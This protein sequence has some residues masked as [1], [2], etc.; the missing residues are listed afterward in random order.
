MRSTKGR[1]EAVGNNSTL[2]TCF[3]FF[4]SRA[5]GS[6]VF[7]RRALPARLPPTLTSRRRRCRRRCRRRRRCCGRRRCRCRCCRCRCRRRRCRRRRTPLARGPLP[8][9]CVFRFTPSPFGGFVRSVCSGE[10][11]LRFPARSVIAA[12]LFWAVCGHAS[13]S[14]TAPCSRK[15]RGASWGSGGGPSCGECSS[16]VAEAPVVAPRTRPTLCTRP[17]PVAPWTAVVL[18]QGG[19]CRLCP[20]RLRRGLLRTAPTRLTRRCRGGT[21]AAAAAVVAVAA[22]TSAPTAAAPRWSHRCPTRRLW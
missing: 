17:R 12:A 9:W 15:Y 2:V 20:W 7:H 16:R 8:T 6:V 1:G 18:K 3:F 19:A 14:S 21:A 10:R 5:G 22:T 11:L 4:L 13:L